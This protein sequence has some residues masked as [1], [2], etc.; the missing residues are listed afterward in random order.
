MKK[1]VLFFDCFYS[2]N[3]L[4]SPLSLSRLTIINKK[5]AKA[6]APK[7]N[8]NTIYLA[9][10]NGQLCSILYFIRS[11]DQFDWELCYAAEGGHL[12]LCKYFINL[13]AKDF[14]QALHY[15]AGGGHIDLCKYFIM[16]GA[17]NFNWSLT[18]AAL[19][20]HLDLCKYFINLGATNF[21]WALENAALYGHLNLCQYFVKLGTTDVNRALASAAQGGHIDLC[22]YFIKLGATEF[23][24]ALRIAKNQSTK[25]F[26]AGLIQEKKNEKKGLVF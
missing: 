23:I 26:L 18:Y 24:F 20:G 13:G 8:S 16:I 7:K 2:F 12:D 6:K 11:K 22:K 10:F 1:R 17:T 4:L 19:G 9:A 3:S 21:N 25:D 15:A 14:N 5:L